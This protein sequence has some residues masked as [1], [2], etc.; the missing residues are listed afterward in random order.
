MSGLRA[1][2]IVF[3]GVGVANLSNYLFHLL[4][5]RSL[6]PSSYGD[7][8]TLAGVI[9]ILTLPLA[10]AQV[11][12]ARHVATASAAGRRLNDEDYVTAFGGAMLTAGVAVTLVLLLCAPLIRSVLSIGSL[13]RRRPGDPLARRRHSS[14]RCWSAR[15]RAASASCFSPWRSPFPRPYGS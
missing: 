8:A 7:V 11:F 6:G 1:S 13:C 5:A 12:V 2:A 10:G 9:G 4:S 3:V 15:R 14:L